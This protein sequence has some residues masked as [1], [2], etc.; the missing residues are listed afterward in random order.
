MARRDK[1]DET[2]GYYDDEG[3]YHRYGVDDFLTEEHP[4]RGRAAKTLGC[5][6]PLALVAG[7][8]YG[9]YRGYNYVRDYFGNNTCKVVAANFDY[10]WSTEQ[11]ANASTIVDVGVGIL[12]MPTRAAQIATATAI[13]ESKL[14]NLT[15]GD[16]DSLGLFQQ[17]TSQGWGTAAQ[18]LDPVY[19]STSFYDALAKIPGWQ[20]L[21][22]TQA[23]QA[24]QKSGF[25]EAY[26]DHET[27]G[28]VL[29]DVF[30]G[31][32]QE[33]VGCRLDPAKSGGM[34]AS[35]VVDKL[36]S[37]SH[38][39]TVAADAHTVN[40][41]PRTVDDAWAIASWA[42][43]HASD[44]GAVKVTVGDREWSR[45]SGRDGWTWHSASRPT[46]GPAAVRIEL[47]G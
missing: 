17:R 39:K 41:N 24:V 3:D 9:G 4:R 47:A 37:Q 32:V 36:Y 33:G 11:T 44:T 42:V 29:A 26:A 1:L 8:A 7:I 34:S 5:V 43:A 16:L 40:G 12:G 15:N 28:R 22:V 23:A 13:Q 10:Q 38:W 35:E 27:Q 46:S 19:A 21:T 6:I 18:I 14:R 25:P 20:N 45:Q 31:R 2:H 30:S